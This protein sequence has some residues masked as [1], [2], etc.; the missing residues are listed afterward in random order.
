MNNELFIEKEIKRRFGKG[1]EKGCPISREGLAMLFGELGFRTGAEIGVQRGLF[2]E[3]LCR[4]I[5][6][7]DLLC[8][9]MWGL[10]GDKGRPWYAEAKERLS[11]H[12]VRFIDKPSLEAAMDIPDRSLDFV[13]IDASHLFDDVMLDIITWGRKVKIGG[14]VAGHDYMKFSF[15]MELQWE[16]LINA[17]KAYTDS[18]LLG[19]WYITS[20]DPASYF[21]VKDFE[22]RTEY[23]TGCI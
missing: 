8:V 10:R 21:W 11:G 12:G 1:R 3:T 7:L 14:V 15:R 20:D 23:D 4:S 6:G 13:Y 9:D 5:P 18:H 22:Q 19:D 17:V 2:S 16:G